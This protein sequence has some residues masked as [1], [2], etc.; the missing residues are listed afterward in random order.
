[1]ITLMRLPAKVVNTLISRLSDEQAAFYFY[2]QASAWCRLNGYEC[3]SKYFTVE[4]HGEEYHF[5]QIVKFLTDWNEKVD[6]PDIKGAIKTFKDLPDIIAQQYEMEC[7]LLKQYEKDAADIFP[8]SQTGYQF[9]QDYVRM[10]N[11]SVVEVGE[12]VNK[13]ENYLKT[14]PGLMLFDRDVFGMYENYY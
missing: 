11:S 5:K 13:L 3:T 9:L 1:M 7:A 8:I 4:S 10:Q 6:F 12:V 2:I 14:D